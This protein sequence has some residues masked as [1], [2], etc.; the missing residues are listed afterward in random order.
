MG[1]PTFITEDYIQKNILSAGPLRSL[2]ASPHLYCI[3]VTKLWADLPIIK[4]CMGQLQPTGHSLDT[5]AIVHL[6]FT[7]KRDGKSFYLEKLQQKYF[8]YY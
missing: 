2:G 7:L 6:D 1:V 5:P 3:K 4:Q 8:K